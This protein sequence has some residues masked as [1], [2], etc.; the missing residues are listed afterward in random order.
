M[1]KYLSV[2]ALE[3][4]DQKDPIWALN[5]AA[6]S[7]INQPGEVH[8]GIPKINGSK[9]DPLYLPQSWLPVCLTDQIPRAQLLAASEFRNAVN[10]NL[11]VLI[12]E[13]FARD[14]MESD[15]VDE[16]RAR[17]IEMKRSVREATAPRGIQESGAEVISTSDLVEAANAPEK[18][19]PDA[20]TPSFVMFANT[21]DAKADIDV[22]NLIRSRAKFSRS[23]MLH[24]VKV[25]HDKPKSKEFVKSRLAAKNK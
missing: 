24:L 9:I 3:Q 16:E 8:V 17:L 12:T 18:E 4:G 2:S 22:L 11:I 25:L 21:L 1:S 19:D 14:I 10:N 6:D 23:E 7:E 5:G 13:K 15:G 20:L